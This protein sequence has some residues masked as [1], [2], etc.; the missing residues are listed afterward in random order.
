MAVLSNWEHLRSKACTQKFTRHH[1]PDR[2]KHAV[3][4]MYQCARINRPVR[5]LASSFFLLA[6]TA[7]KIAVDTGGLMLD[8]ATEVQPL[9]KMLKKNGNES[10]TSQ[11][12]TSKG[13]AQSLQQPFMVTTKARQPLPGSGPLLKWQ[14]GN[15]SAIY[16]YA[17]YRASSPNGNF[18]RIN[19]E[20]VLAKNQGDNVTSSYQYRDNTA[21]S[22]KE[23]W[24]YITIFYNSG[25]KVQLTGP[26]RVVAK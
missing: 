5:F 24:Y 11:V 6:G 21:Q 23:Y 19:Q 1:V 12:D 8:D 7:K 17:I 3:P 13:L 26:Q 15:E 2:R 16:G 20:I 4:T 25:K 18:D 22:G 14:V 9:E 10:G